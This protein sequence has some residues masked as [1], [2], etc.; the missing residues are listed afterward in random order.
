MKITR[1]AYEEATAGVMRL[2][3]DN[4]AL[5][6]DWPWA[7]LERYREY[8]DICNAYELQ[9]ELRMKKLHQDIS[10]ELALE[11]RDIAN[12]EISRWGCA[13]S[14]TK[15]T[16]TIYRM[17]DDSTIETIQIAGLHSAQEAG[18]DLAHIAAGR[19]MA[20]RLLGDSFQLHPEGNSPHALASRVAL[21]AYASHIEPND[22]ELAEEIREWVIK[23]ED[24][25][26]EASASQ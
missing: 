14:R 4:G 17:A 7:D 10:E 21:L 26:C 16:A 1:E 2:L 20:K 22:D 12:S 23:E 8:A 6:S 5:F 18:D 15:D 3:V 11:L 13:I 19:L 24:R 25:C 9:K